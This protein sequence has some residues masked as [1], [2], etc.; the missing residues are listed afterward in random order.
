[1]SGLKFEEYLRALFRKLGYKVIKTRHVGDYGGDL[2]V[3]KNGV[4]TL[5]QAKRYNKKV[6]LDAIQ[7]AVAAKPHYNCRQA[8]VVTNSYF[9]NQAFTLARSNY[10][11]L[12]NRNRLVNVI[13]NSQEKHLDSKK[14]RQLLP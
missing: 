7:Q 9:T 4:R 11:K 8:M 10:V 2:V 12:W 14:L 6:G 1:M 13:L 5:V 3:V